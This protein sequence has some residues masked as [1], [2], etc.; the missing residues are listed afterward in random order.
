MSEELR[1]SGA[2]SPLEPE[3]L[4]QP[5][6]LEQRRQH[7]QPDRPAHRERATRWERS[8]PSAGPDPEEDVEEPSESARLLVKSVPVN[9][10]VSAHGPLALAIVGPAATMSVGHLADVP[11][12]AILAICALQILAAVV[13]RHRR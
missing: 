6:Q 13:M 1:G 11:V 8:R 3:A 12:W 10:E 4:E 7:K 2:P 9:F 5:R